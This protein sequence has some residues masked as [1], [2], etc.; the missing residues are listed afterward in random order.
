MP[1]VSLLLFTLVLATTGIMRLVEVVVSRS[2]MAQQPDAVVSEPALFPAMALLHAGLIFA[3]IAEVWFLDRPF[4]WW[5]GG[6]AMGVLVAATALR[7]WTLRTIGRSWNVRVV[8]PE[9]IKIA[10]TGPYAW[11]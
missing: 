3:P 8:V 4:G 5:I 10:V 7:I 11:I 9:D 6:P 2:R 1:S